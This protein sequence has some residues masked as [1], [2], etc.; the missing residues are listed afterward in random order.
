[1]LKKSKYKVK[2]QSGKGIVLAL[3]EHEMSSVCFQLGQ[4]SCPF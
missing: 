3:N 2:D 4:M 1:M